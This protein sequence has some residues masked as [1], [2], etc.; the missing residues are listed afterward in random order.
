MTFRLDWTPDELARVQEQAFH[1]W[2][3]Y[4][5]STRRTMEREFHELGAVVPYQPREVLHGEY[6][7]PGCRTAPFQVRW[8]ESPPWTNFHDDHVDALAWAL[9]H[10]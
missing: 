10:R 4:G 5:A 6:I 2:L 1:A 3:A 9:G 7:P 8:A